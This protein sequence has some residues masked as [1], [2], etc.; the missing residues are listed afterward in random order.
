M[1]Q[2]YCSTSFSNCICT[3]LYKISNVVFQTNPVAVGVLFAIWMHHDGS[4]QQYN[5]SLQPSELYRVW[6]QAS[7]GNFAITA[8]PSQQVLLGS[9][10]HIPQCMQALV[11]YFDALI[12]AE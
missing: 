11:Q 1:A 5:T 7:F 8:C 4:M 3:V 6:A 2:V 12:Y 9:I 10:Q